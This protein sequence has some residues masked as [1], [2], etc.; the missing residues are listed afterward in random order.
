[1]RLSVILEIG[2]LHG[3]SA[4]N[5]LKATENIPNSIL[6]TI[7]YNEVVTL[8]DRHKCI[9]KDARSVSKKDIDR[10]LDLVFFDCHDYNAQMS[11]YR[12]LSNEGIIND[13]TIIAL[14][15]TNLHY[16]KFVSWAM[17]HN[18][19][20]IHQKVER[21]MVDDF[22]DLNYDIICIHTDKSKHDNTLPFRHGLTIC[23]KF[24]SLTNKNENTLSFRHENFKNLINKYVVVAKYKEDITWVKDYFDDSWHIFVYDKS[25]KYINVGREAETFLRFITEIYNKL[26]KEDTIILLQGNPFDHITNLNLLN[27]INK[28]NTGCTPISEK[29]IETDENGYMHEINITHQ[30]PLKQKWQQIFPNDTQR[31]TW[32]FTPGSQYSIRGEHILKYPKSFWEML[33]NLVYYKNICPWTFERF[34][35]CIFTNV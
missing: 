15:D 29:C 6:Y 23:K 22:K 1:M 7:D 34:W 2:G 28:T 32:L 19:G 8:E 33:H 10:T 27:V 11:L 13:N 31:N 12:N 25:I 24:K 5:F 3:Y 30:L 9:V 18:D 26:E 20:Y 14:H 35:Y 4:K 21:V 16:Q 17:P